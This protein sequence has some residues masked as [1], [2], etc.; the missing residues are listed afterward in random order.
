MANTFD[1]RIRRRHFDSGDACPLASMPTDLHNFVETVNYLFVSRPSGC[2][3]TGFTAF[4]LG[5]LQNQRLVFVGSRPKAIGGAGKVTIAMIE[6]CLSRMSGW[7][8]LSLQCLNYEYPSWHLLLSFSVFDLAAALKGRRTHG[9]GDSFQQDCLERLALA[10]NGNHGELKSQVNDHVAFAQSHFQKKEK[11]GFAAAWVASLKRPSGM[12]LPESA[13]LRKCIH[14]L[15]AWDGFTS[16]EVERGFSAVKRAIGKHRDQIE[17]TSQSKVL[18]LLLDVADSEKQQVARDARKIWLEFWGSHRIS[19]ELRKNFSKPRAIKRD[20]KTTETSFLRTRRVAVQTGVKAHSEK[21]GMSRTDVLEA[22]TAASTLQWGDQQQKAEDKLKERQAKGKA[23]AAIGDNV[24]LP[25]EKDG[26]TKAAAATARLERAKT[27]REHDVKRARVERR[28]TPRQLHNL[29]VMPVWFAP[30]LGGEALRDCRRKLSDPGL[31]RDANRRNESVLFVVQDV[32][33]PG[34]NTALAVRL[35]GGALANVEYYLSNSSSGVAIVY[36]QSN[37][38]KRS[39]FVTPAFALQHRGIVTTLDKC[40]EGSKMSRMESVDQALAYHERDDARP[41]RQR[42]PMDLLCLC[43]VAEKATPALQSKAW[44]MTLDGMLV[45]LSKI[46][47]SA[48][49]MSGL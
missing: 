28:T 37:T 27:D 47:Q 13:I 5:L 43:L 6:R 9:F 35:V 11:D 30:T 41:Q 48:K 42:R 26:Q 32:T 7:V 49:G 4:M 19:G 25:K 12:R 22:A 14:A 31:E 44:A 2:L 46:A 17:D 20:G 33:S 18:K 15:Q 3:K 45:F 38:T 34:Y 36:S 10:F 39:I 40:I 24:L 21:V 16:S 1:R 8:R 29:Y 23:L